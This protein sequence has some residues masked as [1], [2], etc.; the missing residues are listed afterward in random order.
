MQWFK[1]SGF[2]V[3]LLRA[4]RQT[5]YYSLSNYV[6]ESVCIKQINNNKKPHTTYFLPSP[7]KL[8]CLV[9]RNR[10]AIQTVIHSTVPP[11]REVLGGGVGLEHTCYFSLKDEPFS[12][13]CP[14]VT[15]PRSF[16]SSKNLSRDV[17]HISGN[18]TNTHKAGCL[19][20]DFFPCFPPWRQPHR[21]PG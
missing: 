4:K 9:S 10:S 13:L 20:I 6:C 7:M 21:W 18:P 17:V 15:N 1:F 8:P 5:L 14:P 19:R 2:T 16:P 3:S 12:S 11:D